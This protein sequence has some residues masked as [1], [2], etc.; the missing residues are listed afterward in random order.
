MKQSNWL[1]VRYVGV[2]DGCLIY[3]VSVRT[4]HP[5]FWLFVLRTLWRSY[6][7]K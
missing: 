7:S 1:R 2:G 3:D 6:R 4:W 5:G